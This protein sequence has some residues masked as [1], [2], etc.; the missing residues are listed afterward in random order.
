MGRCIEAS[1]KDDT[2]R[3]RAALAYMRVPV[4]YP[5][6]SRCAECLYRAAMIQTGT[7]R[8]DRAASLLREA[9]RHSPND[10]LKRRCE[11]ALASKQPKTDR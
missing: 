9:L 8:T 6:D 3:L 11:A 10:D 4:H 5:D 1:A 2:D 7:G